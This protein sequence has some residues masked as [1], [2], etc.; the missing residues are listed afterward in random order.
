M[1][2]VI[3]YSLALSQKPVL[4]QCNQL[5][6]RSQINI[7]LGDGAEKLKYVVDELVLSVIVISTCDCKL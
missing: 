1:V 7:Q 6:V 4:C 5:E 3:V 2:S